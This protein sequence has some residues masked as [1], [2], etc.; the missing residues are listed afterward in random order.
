MPVSTRLI[1][2]SRLQSCEESPQAAGI[3]RLGTG[4]L[5]TTT[6][7]LL[8]E[9]CIFRMHQVQLSEMQLQQSDIIINSASNLH[10]QQPQPDM[11]LTPFAA[12]S[13]SFFA[14]TDDASIFN[15]QTMAD[16]DMLNSDRIDFLSN[17]S[18]IYNQFNESPAPLG[19]SLNDE[20][21]SDF[22]TQ[23]FGIN[24]AV[25]HHNP[26]FKSSSEF[27][28]NCSNA[29]EANLAFGSCRD[30]YPSIITNTQL[31][32]ACSASAHSE[33]NHFADLICSAEHTK[34][35]NNTLVPF[36]QKPIALPATQSEQIFVNSEYEEAER[37]ATK[38]ILP[39]KRTISAAGI[40]DEFDDILDELNV[41]DDMFVE[42]P[43][44]I[45]PREISE[46]PFEQNN[47]QYYSTSFDGNY[48][49]NKRKPAPTLAT[50]RKSKDEYLPPDEEQKRKLRRERN[51]YAAAKCRKKRADLTKR[52]ESESELLENNINR[53][54]LE[55]A[56][57]IRERDELELTLLSQT[58]SNANYSDSKDNF[59][60]S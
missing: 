48:G 50:G 40:S 10:A 33:T 31:Q 27:I 22:T 55:I 21:S 4:N 28:T 19:S 49:S 24:S 53:L 54:K 44:S 25:I 52:L 6:M 60:S 58:N 2:I 46:N 23:L 57:L 11:R 20:G 8:E 32:H 7:R 29:A 56:Q 36:I 42:E 37:S 35:L 15:P 3:S 39:R 38:S 12:A 41:G 1:Q 14:L 5:G 16:A 47:T 51:K 59:I 13:A 43:R 45:M 34:R 9:S 26:I 30:E 18:S 17:S